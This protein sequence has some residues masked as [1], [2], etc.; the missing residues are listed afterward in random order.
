MNNFFCSTLCTLLLLNS[1]GVYAVDKDQLEISKKIAVG[2]H[3][4]LD[5]GGAVPFPLSKALGDDDKMEAVPGL[6]PSIGLSGTYHLTNRWSISIEGTY[7]KVSLEADIVT[8]TTGQKFIIDGTKVLFRGRASTDMEFSMIEFPLYA[9]F[10]ITENN[11]VFLGGYGTYIVKGK[12]E[13]VAIHGT[14]SDPNDPNGLPTTLNTPQH[15][16][17][18]KNLSKFDAGMLLG[19][20]YGIT[21][22]LNLSGR[23]IVGFKDIFKKGENYLDYSMWH[24]RGN[25]VLSFTLFN[26]P[27]H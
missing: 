20:E 2:L 13:A 26:S 24:M 16:N 4:G 11:R 22:R 25:V 9:R 15:Q 3:T 5:I 27:T 21:K 14:I 17:F 19:Y 1:V 18:S 7:K 8:L 12:F 23:I 10:R 6:T